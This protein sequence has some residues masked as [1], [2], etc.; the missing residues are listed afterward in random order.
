MSDFTSTLIVK[1]ALWALLLFSVLTWALILIKGVQSWRTSHFNRRYDKTFWAASD[2]ASAAEL[3]GAQS[4]QGRVA[5]AAFS[6]LLDTGHHSHDL[7]HSWD[8]L[9]LLERHLRQQI[10]KERR[11]F[12][13][14]LAVLA[15]IGSTAPFVGLFGTV[16]GIIHALTAITHS[17]SASIDVVAGPIGEA[18]IATGVGIAVAVPAVLAYNFFV[19]RLKVLGANLDNFATDFIGLAQKSQYRIRVTAKAATAGDNGQRGER[20]DGPTGAY[21]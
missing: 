10:V 13:N 21:A 16:F 4:P 12:E 2:F 6:A 8:R 19:R 5:G 17:A 20:G 3:D 11:S 18:L 1:G 7:E 9:E 15:S 14:G